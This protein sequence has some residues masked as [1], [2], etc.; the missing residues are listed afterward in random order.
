MR[1]VDV[2]FELIATYR[3][4]MPTYAV[5]AAFGYALI[6]DDIVDGVSIER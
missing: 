5:A 4:S 3:V 1:K 6:S 2:G